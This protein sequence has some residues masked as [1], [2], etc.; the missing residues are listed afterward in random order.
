MLFYSKNIITKDSINASEI[1]LKIQTPKSLLLNIW[2]GKKEKSLGS[3]LQVLDQEEGPIKG[4]YFVFVR[5]GD[6]KP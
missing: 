4:Q 3:L 6:I 5:Y 2:I 1:K